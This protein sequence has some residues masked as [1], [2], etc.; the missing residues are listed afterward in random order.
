MLLRCEMSYF[1]QLPFANLGRRQT[2]PPLEV[3]A[4]LEVMPHAALLVNAQTLQVVQ[5]NAHATELTL[6][7]RAE[8]AGQPLAILF[9][10]WSFDQNSEIAQAG[11]GEPAQYTLKLNQ[12]N[13]NLQ[14]VHCTLQFL[15]PKN[16]WLLVIIELESLFLKRQAEIQSQDRF[17]ESL[18]KLINAAQTSTPDEALKEAMIAGKN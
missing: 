4:M 12:H 16:K 3:Q 9:P 14:D 18:H 11:A 7:T 15:T 6:Y 1:S 17:W 8:L 10:S 13:S 2:L 5:A